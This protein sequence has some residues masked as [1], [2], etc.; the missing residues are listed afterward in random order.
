MGTNDKYAG[1]KAVVTGGTAGIGLATAK[2]LI[3]GGAAVIVTG[4]TERNLEEASRE[5]GPKAHVVQ[6]DA[7]SLNDID[8][9]GKIVAEKFGQVDFVFIN[10]GFCKL[11]PFDQITEAVYDKTFDI[12][13]KGVFFTVQRLAPLVRRGGSFLFMTSVAD[14]LGY[15][16]MS[17][18]SASRAAVRSLARVFASELLPNGLR[19]N[20][21]SPGFIRTQTMGIAG[22]SME[23]VEAFIKEGEEVTPMKRIGTLDEAVRAILFLGFDATFTTGAELTV[24]GGIGQGIYAPHS[25]NA[26]A[27]KA[28][29]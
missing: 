28:V 9:L 26:E 18:F 19:V 17:A 12:N 16:M 25:T 21:I 6:S 27:A 7:A 23:D 13:T 10:A 14:E 5:L 4:Q 3:E 29:S 8:A 1:K 11:E 20:A 2:A 22:A 15:P 24:D